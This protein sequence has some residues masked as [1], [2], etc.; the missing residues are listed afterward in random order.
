MHWQVEKAV[1][2]VLDRHLNIWRLI[3]QCLQAG[4]LIA[5]KSL[6]ASAHTIPI[7]IPKTNTSESLQ[8]NSAHTG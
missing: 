5:E 8:I 3:Y 4:S 1:W 6:K 7:A 2:K